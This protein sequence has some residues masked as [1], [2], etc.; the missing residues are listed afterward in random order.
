M[1]EERLDQILEQALSPEIDE[2]EIQIRRKAVKMNIKKVLACGLAACVALLVVV[3]GLF[4]LGGPFSRKSS[5]GTDESIVPKN[6]IFALTAYAAELPKDVTSG[7]CVGLSLAMNSHG[8]DLMHIDPIFF[9]SGENIERI[10]ISTDKCNIF[11]ATPSTEEE[12]TEN[13]SNNTMSDGYYFFSDDNG[14]VYEHLVVPGQ[15]YEGTYNENMSFGMSVPQELWSNND[16]PKERYH[17]TTYQ[18]DGAIL[19]VEV[20]YTDGSIETHHYKVTVGK[21]YVP[22]DENGHNMYDAISRFVV[23]EEERYFFGY[24]LSQID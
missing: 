12:V 13:L 6:N 15:T 11:Y 22:L 2:S 18:V 7:E 24:L 8:G 1:T 19:T 9:I 4:I 20:T 14:I 16:D 5:N 3:A 17:E 10:K 23:N 21:I